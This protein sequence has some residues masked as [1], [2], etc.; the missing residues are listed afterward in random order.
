M[1][2]VRSLIMITIMIRAMTMPVVCRD[3]NGRGRRTE[4]KRPV[5]TLTHIA[6]NLCARWLCTTLDAWLRL[7][8]GAIDSYPD[9]TI[10]YVIYS[11]T[12]KG[13]TTSDM[14]KRNTPCRSYYLQILCCTAL[15]IGWLI[16]G[17]KL[18]VSQSLSQSRG[19]VERSVQTSHM[20]RNESLIV[21]REFGGAR[22]RPSSFISIGAGL[23]RM[24]LGSPP[25]RPCTQPWEGELD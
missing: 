19:E 12:V 23:G 21:G 3:G 15:Y 11:H 9:G 18:P 2:N 10:A 4:R 5:L 1:W 13:F 25:I 22:Y 24:D 16:C 7:T 17:W 14:A 6:S 8:Q 20:C